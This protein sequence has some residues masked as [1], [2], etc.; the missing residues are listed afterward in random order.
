MRS[1]RI[2]TT[3]I[4][5]PSP[6][7]V[8]HTERRV[9]LSAA[10]ACFSRMRSRRACPEQSP[11][12]PCSYSPHVRRRHSFSPDILC[13]IERSVIPSAAF[14]CFSRMRSRRIP[15]ATIPVPSPDILRHTERRA[16]LR[17]YADL[18]RRVTLKQTAVPAH[19][20]RNKKARTP[21]GWLRRTHRKTMRVPS[22]TTGFLRLSQSV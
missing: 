22:G 7:I 15:T 18:S 21:K 13:H 14:A 1:R 4:P 2:P 9:I 3:T 8:R 20:C 11:Y 12:D 19:G 10:F 17:C 16:I 6:D 5:V